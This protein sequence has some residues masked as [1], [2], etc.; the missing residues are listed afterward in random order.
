MAD[1]TVALPDNLSAEE[2]RNARAVLCLNALVNAGDYGAMDAL[3]AADYAD[4]NPGWQVESLAELK[5][6]IR[7]GHDAFGV[8]NEVDWIIAAGDK[9]FVRVLNHGRHAAAVF[10]K[11]PTGKETCM[12]T[13]E[14]YRF[15]G[16]RIV[17]RWVVSDLI[18]LMRQ[19]G[20]ELPVKL[21]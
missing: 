13:F 14:I 21:S 11:P 9:V 12:T 20:V 1:K 7:F 5:K 2:A 19:L 8:R 3:F 10:G 16:G 18:G 17:E 6:L 4:H 15:Q